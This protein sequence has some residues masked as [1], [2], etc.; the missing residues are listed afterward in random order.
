MFFVTGLSSNSILASKAEQTIKTALRQMNQ[1]NRKVKLYHSFY[2][3][4]DSWSKAERVILK[5][6]ANPLESKPNVRFILTNSS[7]G[8]A[9]V[10]YEQVYCKR[11]VCELYIKDHKTYLKSD[12]TSCSSFPANQFRLFLH[13]AAYVL[14]HALRSTSLQSTEFSRA[15][16]QTIQLKIFKLGARV[17]ELKTKIKVELPNYITENQEF[18]SIFEIL[19]S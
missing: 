2:Y 12:R 6:E 5:V 11:A 8:R 18:R 16:M 17:K 13:S 15:T 9:K 3:K 7:L 14:I 10:L 1:Q 19:R 4:A